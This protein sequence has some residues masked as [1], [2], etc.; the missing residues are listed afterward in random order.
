VWV[1]SG[2]VRVPFVR[3]QRTRAVGHGAPKV[4]RKTTRRSLSCCN[5]AVRGTPQPY[6]PCQNTRTLLHKAS[7]LGTAQNGCTTLCRIAQRAPHR[8]QWSRAGFHFRRSVT[9]PTLPRVSVTE[10]SSTERRRPSATEQPRRRRVSGA[11]QGC[12]RTRCNMK[13]CIH[14]A[15]PA[16][17]T[18]LLVLSHNMPHALPHFGI[19]R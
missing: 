6:T 11:I 10:R 12:M 15:M 8:R 5:P 9:E 13:R 2:T 7:C 14:Y 3:G 17:H 18:T 1:P 4:G 19:V 16:S